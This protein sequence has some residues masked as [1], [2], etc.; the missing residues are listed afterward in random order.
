[1]LLK[2]LLSTVVLIFA[3][4]ISSVAQS[5]VGFY[6]GYT[7]AFTTDKVSTPSRTAHFGYLVGFDARLNDDEFHFKGGLEYF[8]FDLISNSNPIPIKKGQMKMLKVRGGFGLHLAKLSENSI[9]RAKLLGSLQFVR[10]YDKDALVIPEYT[11]INENLAGVATGIG[12][13]IG[14]L[15]ID[16][17]F[18]YGLFNLYFKKPNSKLHFINFNVGFFL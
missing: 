9:L 18:D 13:D 11:R 7:T 12:V 1:M 15:T 10:D 6:A 16:L 3:L 14:K 8:S 17:E 2:D 5:G 4:Y